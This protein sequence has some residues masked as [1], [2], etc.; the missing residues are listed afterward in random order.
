MYVFGSY[1]ISFGHPVSDLCLNHETIS[2][3]QLIYCKYCDYCMVVSQLRINQCSITMFAL[4][5]MISLVKIPIPTDHTSFQKDGNILGIE[6]LG[7]KY[8]EYL[9]MD[10]TIE[11]IPRATSIPGGP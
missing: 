10:I 4:I 2:Y 1:H 5:S 7:F 11:L 9:G 6:I 3:C 8:R